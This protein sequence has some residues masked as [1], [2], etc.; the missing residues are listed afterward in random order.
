[1]TEE[2]VKAVLVEMKLKGDEFYEGG[3]IVMYRTDLY[4]SLAEAEKARGAVYGD[5]CDSMSALHDADYHAGL[6]QMLYKNKLPVR[7]FI[8]NGE[9]TLPIDLAHEMMSGF[10]D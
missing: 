8:C 5:E 4:S 9:Y 6:I 3:H 10:Y 1:M 7:M 2:E